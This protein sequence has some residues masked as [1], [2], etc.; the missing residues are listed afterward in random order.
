MRERKTTSPRWQ[1]FQ[2]TPLVAERRCA[3]SN[4]VRPATSKFQSTPLVA[5]RRCASSRY[6]LPTNAGFNPRPSL[7]RGD[8]PGRKGIASWNKTFQS[9]P[10]VAERRCDP[11]AIY[12]AC[13]H[14]FNPRPSLP[15]G[16]ACADDGLILAVGS[17]N[18][19]PSLPRGD[20]MIITTPVELLRVSIHAPRCREAM[21]MPFRL[22][23]HAVEFQS[24]PLVAE[25]RC[26]MYRASSPVA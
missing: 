12:G 20:A 16:D 10:L 26:A 22:L 1:A 2:S 9:T 7:P 14:C 17:F 18:P 23:R 25:R 24:T 15:R 13:I 8:A 6:L 11:G 21:P 3:R 19:R 4:S 5:E